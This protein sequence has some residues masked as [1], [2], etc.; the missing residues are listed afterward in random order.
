MWDRERGQLE[1]IRK[2]FEFPKINKVA[3][4]IVFLILESALL[5]GG[6]SL[7]GFGNAWSTYQTPLMMYMVMS[8]AY[9]YMDK[10]GEKLK[11]LKF[12][13]SAMW[14]VIGFIIAWAIT[15]LIV[16]ALS[17]QPNTILKSQSLMI[18]TWH[19]I[20]AANEELI[21][22][23][24]LPNHVGGLAAT[25]LFAIFHFATYGWNFGAM[26]WAFVLGAVFLYA[27]RK[28]GN[29]GISIGLHWGYNGVLSG[30]LIANFITI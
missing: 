8:L 5:I 21:F 25:F 13:T 10:S 7:P 11:D 2:Q 30:V 22:R 4:L 6:R 19:G 14:V 23:G 20:V 16:M 12:T 15:L 29:L 18:L 24:V 3:F 1:R 26:M 17:I 28:I 9:L 27:Y